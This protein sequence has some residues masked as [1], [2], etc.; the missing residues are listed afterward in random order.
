MARQADDSE[1]STEQVQRLDHCISEFHKA[2]D[3]RFDLKC[4]EF[5]K[6][7]IKGEIALHLHV[8]MHAEV[9]PNAQDFCAIFCRPDIP[10]PTL[11][12]AL[13]EF[14]IGNLSWRG[15]SERAWS[16][17]VD[18]DDNEQGVLVGIAKVVE[19][20]KGMVRRIGTPSCSFKIRLTPLNECLRRSG[21]A[22]YY[23][24]LSGRYEFLLT[25]ADGKLHFEVGRR[26]PSENKRPNQM[27]EAGTQ[28]VNNL[29]GEHREAQWDR[30]FRAESAKNVLSDLVIHL[31]RNAV[32]VGTRE[33]GYFR[34]EAFDVLVGPLNLRPTPIEWM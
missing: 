1:L 14:C 12:D 25:G 3:D 21:Y 23:S 29:S 22:L 2:W 11:G 30:S 28:M 19:N 10:G 13:N 20:H 18:R 26:M 27:I 17:D 24:P 32:I 31:S 9:E 15:E 5:L 7:Y 6:R 33:G 4:P 16:A 8:R 34:S